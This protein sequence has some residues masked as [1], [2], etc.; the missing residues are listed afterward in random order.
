MPGR[1]NSYE[2]MAKAAVEAIEQQRQLGEQLV[3]LPDE[4]SGCAPSDDTGTVARGKGKA[5]NQMREFMAAKG[6]RMPEEVLVQIAGLATNEDAMILA[7]QRAEQVITW[8]FAGATRMVKGEEKKVHPSPEQRLRA[9]ETQYTTILRANDALMPYGTP[10]AAPAEKTA[11]PIQIVVPGGNPADA[12]QARD[13][14]PPPA[15][16]GSKMMPADVV[17]EMQQNQGVTNDD[18]EKSDT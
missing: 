4:G 6:Y 8:A 1:D 13:V 7:M 14:T 5:L 11:P 10:K 3:L 15:Q 16:I 2:A 17:Y 12:P 18:D 9:F